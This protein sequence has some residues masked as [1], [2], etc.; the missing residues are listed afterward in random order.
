MKAE[1]SIAI[2][3]AL[4]DQSRIAIV[5]SLLEQPQYVEEIARRHALATSTVSFHLRKLE[6]AGL[7]TSRKEQY[8]AVFQ[9]NDQIFAT[10]LREIVSVPPAGKELQDERMEEYRQKVL[11]SFF[12]NG[13]LEKLP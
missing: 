2:M 11:E 3:K 9:A 7:V 8:Y 13:R 6:Q 4:A 12:R 10:T 5:N 1:Q